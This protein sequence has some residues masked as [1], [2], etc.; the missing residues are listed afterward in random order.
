[1]NRI[2]AGAAVSTMLS[3]L[4]PQQNGLMWWGQCSLR[5]GGPGQRISVPSGYAA[6]GA[7]MAPAILSGRISSFLSAAGRATVTGSAESGQSAG[8]STAAATGL[9]L[10]HLSSTVAATAET[11][12]SIFA[13]VFVA[14]ESAG[15][16]ET[17]GAADMVVSSEAASDGVSSASGSMS[18]LVGLD[19]IVEASA[20]VDNLP[21]VGE[22]SANASSSGESVA[23]LAITAA[24]GCICGTS[25]SAAS[26]AIAGPF[27]LGSL[28]GSTA[29]T[30]GQLTAA[31]VADA[32]WRYSR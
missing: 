2:F 24:L 12:G 19:A 26:A 11:G 6:P 18:A 20:S 23:E 22:L 10:G 21:L 15:S 25:S 31:E 8:S 32:V 5:S 9:G 4:A 27:A 30:G 29:D 28:G 14:G 13:S 3:G 7:G 17:T 1:M 16:A